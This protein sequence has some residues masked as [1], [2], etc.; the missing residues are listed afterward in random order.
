MRIAAAAL[1]CA[2]LTACT[3]GGLPTS[4][5]GN[6]GATAL[7]IDINLTNSIPAQIPQGNAG[8]YAP[9]LAHVAVGSTIRFTNT[10]GFSHTA[11]L[12]PGNPATFPS[13]YPFTAAALSQTGAKLSQGWSTGTLPAGS[14]SQTLTADVAGTYVF[15]CFYHYGAPMRGA[16]VVQ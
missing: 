16:I 2:L 12:I 9:L 13:A 11:T 4:G 6:G 15:G 7:V 10:D 1:G 8:A 5:G 3:P 14:S